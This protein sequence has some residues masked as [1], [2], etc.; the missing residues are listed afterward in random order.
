MARFRPKMFDEFDGAPSKD[1]TDQERKL[2]AAVGGRRQP[3][4][5]SSMYAKGDVKFGDDK[6]TIDANGFLFDSKQTEA[7]S[8]GVTGEMLEKISREALAE[9]RHPALE[10]EIKGAKTPMARETWI[11][12]PRAVFLRLL[13]AGAGS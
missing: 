4:S 8:L 2:A 9:E 1:P 10:L 3:G 7:A 13:N 11:V 6:N 5:G 12:L